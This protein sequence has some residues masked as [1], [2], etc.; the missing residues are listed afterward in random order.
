MRAP[1]I[2]ATHTWLGNAPG[3]RGSDHAENYEGAAAGRSGRL[4][5]HGPHPRHAGRPLPRGRDVHGHKVKASAVRPHWGAVHRHLRRAYPDFRWGPGRNWGATRW[6][7]RRLPRPQGEPAGNRP[8]KHPGRL[9]VGGQCPHRPPGGFLWGQ[10]LPRGGRVE[11]RVQARTAARA[12]PAVL[13]R[14]PHSVGTGPDPLGPPHDGRAQPLR[15][16]QAL[17][18]QISA[19]SLTPRPTPTTLGDS[20]RPRELS[21]VP[22][23]ISLTSFPSAILVAV[24]LFMKFIFYPITFPRAASVA[25]ST[26]YCA[27]RNCFKYSRTL[28]RIIW[29]ESPHSSARVFI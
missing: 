29:S 4:R 24:F 18:R 8:R 15:P 11:S 1:L 3:H 16:Q 26:S 28:P 20:D 25:R 23:F 17:R 7:E 5:Q 12:G 6:V 2:G 10:L 21:A 27:D 22:A 9:V 14:Q 19:S 13:V